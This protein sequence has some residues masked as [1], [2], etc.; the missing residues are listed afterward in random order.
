MHSPHEVALLFGK[1][2]AYP[3]DKEKQIV[4]PRW[5]IERSC[6]GTRLNGLLDRQM[7]KKTR[8]PNLAG[9]KQSSGGFQVIGRAVAPI[10]NLCRHVN[11]HAPIVSPTS[12]REKTADQS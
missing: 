10:T 11:C 6:D 9:Y 5:K 2:N 3:L 8:L 12:Q 7:Y 1:G 4:A